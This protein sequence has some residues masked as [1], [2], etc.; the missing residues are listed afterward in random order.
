MSLWEW[1]AMRGISARP[2]S[3]FNCQRGIYGKVDNVKT[4]FRWIAVS[5]DFTRSRKELHKRFNPG[6]E[7]I[8]FIPLWWLYEGRYY[9][10]SC[11]ISAARDS[12]GRQ[13][14][15][16]QILEWEP[17]R[18]APIALGALALLSSVATAPPVDW[19]EWGSDPGWRDETF[20][21]PLPTP[22]IKLTQA[23]LEGAAERGLSDLRSFSEKALLEFYRALLAR[24]PP[25][26][27][28]GLEKPLSPHALAALLLPLRP[29]EC[30]TQSFAG[31]ET[32]LIHW[33]GMAC[34]RKPASLSRNPDSSFPP[35]IEDRAA[36]LAK[37]ILADDPELAARPCDAV[38]S[39]LAFARDSGE[40]WAEAARLP[41]TA[42]TIKPA[43]TELLDMAL[44]ALH[45]PPL[46]DYLEYAHDDVKDAFLRHMAAKAEVIKA[47]WLAAALPDDLAQW[48]TQHPSTGEV[49][50]RKVLSLWKEQ[51]LAVRS[52]R[53]LDPVTGSTS[54]ITP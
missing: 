13:F 50:C 6:S 17:P 33:S 1:P 29:D 34:S 36:M 22:Q 11:Y 45:Q 43:E 38:R 42:S 12:A 48:L 39:I 4:D 14:I 9:A 26:L 37:A 54:S 46:P 7:R 25:A 5:T 51:P 28:T 53:Q 52:L 20:V 41:K 8:P 24:R 49:T 21:K 35:E 40:R 32:E 23:E 27:L 44:L 47:W 30:A 10:S 15:E 31:W 16:T 19:C 3:R 2:E 18:D